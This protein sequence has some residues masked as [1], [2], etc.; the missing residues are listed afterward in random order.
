VVNSED[1]IVGLKIGNW[2]VKT[3]SGQKVTLT[4]GTRTTTMSLGRFRFYL[5]VNSEN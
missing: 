1:N 3:L 5:M 4:N 2:T